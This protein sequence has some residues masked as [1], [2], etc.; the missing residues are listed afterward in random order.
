MADNLT[1]PVADATVLGA[2]DIGGVKYPWNLLADLT[3]ADAMG[4]AASNPTA[5]TLLGRLKAIADL[6]TLTNGYVDGL[7]GLQ[8]TANNALAQIVGYVDGLETLQ[9]A[10]NTTLT[11]IAGYLDGVE[12]LLAA[13]TPAGEA[14]IGKTGGDV[15][16]CAPA[17][18]PV[19]TASAYAAG[20]VLG[21]KFTLPN[22]ARLAGGAG[23]IQ[24]ASILCKS[25]NTAA[26]DL[27]LFSADPTNSALTDKTA[28]AINAA[29]YAKVVGVIHLT[30]WTSLGS[31][32]LGQNLA[33]GLPFR[34][35]AGFDL[36]AVMVARGAVTLGSVADLLPSVRIIPG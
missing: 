10:S 3:G 34:V 11:A 16:V 29:D 25:A 13:P 18:A 2:K 30:D 5:Y 33:V 6:L 36:F 31:A 32:A 28:L 7:E 35:P 27:I 8:T 22:A 24:S 26:V 12:G 17:A 1:T 23:L 19:T 4:L 9:G 21:T 20:N 15:L 14:Y